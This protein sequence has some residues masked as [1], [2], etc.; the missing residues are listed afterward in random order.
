VTPAEEEAESAKAS[1][2]AAN[3]DIAN[4]KRRYAQNSLLSAAGFDGAAPQGSSA[5]L[6]ALGPTNQTTLG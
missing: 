4:K 6:Q 2:Q 3:R 5:L 1:A